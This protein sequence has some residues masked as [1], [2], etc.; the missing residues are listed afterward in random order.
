MDHHLAAGVL[1]MVL[2]VE[3]LTEGVHS[4]SAGGVVP[5]SF[6]ILRS[7]LSRI[8]DERSG[9]CCCASYVDI[10]DQRLRQITATAPG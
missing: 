2:R 8:E 4:G 5:S 1:D 3:V 10:P 7:L 6:R 9:N